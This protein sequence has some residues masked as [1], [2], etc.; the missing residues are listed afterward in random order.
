[1]LDK[2]S[3]EDP[4]G[5]PYKGSGHVRIN[6]ARRIKNE[7]NKPVW[8]ALFGEP[9]CHCSSMEGG[10]GD[11]A[12][13]EPKVPQD[14]QHLAVCSVFTPVGDRSA[15]LGLRAT[16]CDVEQCTFDYIQDMG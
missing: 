8:Q 1:V 2:A 7:P 10:F 16:T 15:K 9:I 13:V 5:I 3:D 4:V 14:G 12:H 11:D 6:M